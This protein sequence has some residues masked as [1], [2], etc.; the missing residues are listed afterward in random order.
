MT[1]M[2]E[3]PVERARQA[4]EDRARLAAV[5]AEIE[6][7]RAWNWDHLS[8]AVATVQNSGLDVVVRAAGGDTDGN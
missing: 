1:H 4:R 2:T 8:R 3:I 5:L 6:R 7:L